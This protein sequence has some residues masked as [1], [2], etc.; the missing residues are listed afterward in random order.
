MRLI[1]P[2]IAAVLATL[3][4]HHL[5]AQSCTP[6]NPFPAGQFIVPLPYT[7]ANPEQGIQDTAYVN[8]PY[9]TNFY[10]K[11]P[12]T[13][14][15]NGVTLPVTNFS[16]PTTG[17]FQNLPAGLTYF[18]NPPNCVF[19]AEQSGC[20]QLSGTLSPAQVDVYDLFIS[21]TLNSIL[22]IPLVLPAPGIVEG[23]YYLHVKNCPYNNLQQSA[24][25]CS[26]ESYTFPDGTVQV[27]TENT[28]QTSTFIA[29]NGCD[30]LVTTVVSVATVDTGLT[31]D[32]N[33]LTASASGST[34]QWINCNGNQPIAGATNAAF[35]PA[36]TGNYAVIVNN[37]F[38]QDTSACFNV[39]ISS[40]DDL[41]AEAALTIAP[42][43]VGNTLQLVVSGLTEPAH[44]T[45][46]DINGLEMIPQMII[47]TPTT[48]IDV[49]ALAPGCYFLTLQSKEMVAV[50]KF[51]K[52]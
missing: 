24:T 37:G 1:Y 50:R 4:V 26:G 19:A 35:T 46:R 43:P 13:V 42:N 11:I 29:S 44:L 15:L 6:L 9:V 16:I 30:S 23:N 36:A 48:G 27:I 33:T 40:I 32:G 5:Q 25:V 7:E 2:L 14:T 34:F 8:V 18:C 20:V 17:A 28:V 22:P 21:G 45:I 51:F 31:Q 47:S 3:S 38:C 41:I 49:T 52:K 39:I 12:T 10:F